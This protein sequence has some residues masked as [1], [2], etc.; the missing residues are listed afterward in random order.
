[1]PD[2]HDIPRV[3][4]RLAAL[5]ASA[6]TFVSLALLMPGWASAQEFALQGPATATPSR[7]LGPIAQTNAAAYTA[8]M[9]TQTERAKTPLP[10]PELAT[11]DFGPTPLPYFGDQ[12]HRLTDS[13]AIIWAG[14]PMTFHE[15]YKLDRENLPEVINEFEQ[16]D[17]PYYPYRTVY[18]GALRQGS[19]QGALFVIDHY[20]TDY[21][22][23]QVYLTP[24]QQGAV[25][26]V[27]AFGHVLLIRS[28][29]TGE[30]IEFN[31]DDREFR[32][33]V[34]TPTPTAT[35]TPPGGPRPPARLQ[36]YVLL[37][38]ERLHLGVGS[39]V[40]SGNVGVNAGPD[41]MRSIELH[42]MAGA[43]IGE[44]SSLSADS[45][46]LG[47]FARIPGIV[48]YNDLKTHRF[49]H[50]GGQL[51]SPLEL[52][53]AALPDLPEFSL[54][55]DARDYTVQMAEETPFWVQTLLGRVTVKSD[56]VLVLGGGVHVIRELRIEAHG[57]VECHAPCELRITESVSLGPGA[58]LGVEDRLP[59]ENMVVYIAGDKPNTFHAS[60]GSQIAAT[61][62]APNGTLWLGPGGDYQGAFIGRQIFVLAGS[63]L[64]LA[65]SFAQ[66]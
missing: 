56:G 28:Q 51:I 39:Q 57:R 7:T 61:I 33:A 43:Q 45:V 37:A 30:I 62:V 11:P 63:R 27:D 14:I 52:P 59:P 44:H 53:L 54:G 50:V 9:L 12:T 65:S 46:Y 13:G 20:I 18:A 29:E 1:M 35:P 55:T 40:L 26:I 31:I 25:E 47:A 66:H 49:G 2:E 38:S 32:P 58:F 34:P 16:T 17:G 15:C 3:E 42:V 60:A 64:Q 19:P 6:L 22:E 10:T 4:R 21:C 8:I 41:G 24:F 23:P 48:F 36:D 5:F